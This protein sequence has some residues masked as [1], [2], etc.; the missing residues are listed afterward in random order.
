M[1]L[2]PSIYLCIYIYI[3]IHISPQTSH[4]LETRSTLLRP[5]DKVTATS[6]GT[7]AIIYIYIYIIR[8][9][10]INSNDSVINT[11]IIIHYHVIMI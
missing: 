11:Y 7:F 5:A 3:Y 8:C 1:F 2:S 4:R 10:T 6:A 9:T